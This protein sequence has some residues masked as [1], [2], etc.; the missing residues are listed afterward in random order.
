MEDF[1]TSSNIAE[2]DAWVKRNAIPVSYCEECKK[3]YYLFVN[4][5]P[6]EK[7]MIFKSC[8][9]HADFK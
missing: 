7:K 6:L 9:E 8:Q 5:K 1:P 4:Y 2:W 3:D